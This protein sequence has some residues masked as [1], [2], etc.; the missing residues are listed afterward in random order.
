MTYENLHSHMKYHNIKQWLLRGC[1]DEDANTIREAVNKIPERR[2][3]RRLAR[4]LS[5]E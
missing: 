5:E 4:A 1:D 2:L 3:I